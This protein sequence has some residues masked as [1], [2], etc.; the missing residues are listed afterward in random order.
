M[1]FWFEYPV[2]V[3]PHHT[4]YAGIVWHGTY[5]SWMEEARIA[6]LKTL[7]LGFSDWVNTGVD[8]P[9]VD[10]SLQYRQS[11]TLGDDAVVK[12]SL[13]P[14]SGVRMVWQYDIQNRAHGSTCLRGTVT[15]VPVDFESRKILR[16]LPDSI[17]AAL[18]RLCSQEPAP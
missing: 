5:I 8:L 1:A 12:T 6:Y 3:Q 13:K 16:R 10:L 2:T 15:L 18:N 9:V 14:R 11:L 7:G 17:Q 4:D